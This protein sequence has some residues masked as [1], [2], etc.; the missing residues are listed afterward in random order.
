MHHSFFGSSNPSF[1]TS[2]PPAPSVPRLNVNLNLSGGLPQP[3]IS[4]TA[5]A[6]YAASPNTSVYVQAGNNLPVAHPSVPTSS[7]SESQVS[8]GVV[9]R[10][11]K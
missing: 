10:L 2:T 5:T 7:P 3:G 6:T 4:A 8:G 1:P 9:F 11:G